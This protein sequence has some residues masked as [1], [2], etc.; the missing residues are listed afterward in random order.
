MYDS[1]SAALLCDEGFHT[2]E[3]FSVADDDDSCRG[4]R[5]HLFQLVEIGG[6]AI[7]G[8][9]NFGFGVAGGRH[10]VKGIT[11]RGSSRQGIAVDVL[12]VGRASRPR[13]RGHVYA[14]FG[15]IV[16][17]TLYWTISV[18]SPA[19]AKLFALRIRRC[20]VFGEPAMWGAWVECG[21]ALR[22]AWVGTAMNFS[23]SSARRGT[24]R[25]PLIDQLSGWSLF[26]SFLSLFFPV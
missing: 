7:V 6:G 8:I 16:E 14:N 24:S 10:A 13:G 19:A 3:V 9:D 15:G 22:R 20:F 21:G 23:S 4:R 11:T 12:A 25:N 18:S 1:G 26:L 2:A 17:P 5:V